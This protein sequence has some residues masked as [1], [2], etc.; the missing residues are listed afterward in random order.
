MSSPCVLTNHGQ[1]GRIGVFV[2]RLL[3][4]ADIH[5]G[6]GSGVGVG[7]SLDVGFLLCLFTVGR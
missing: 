5:T 3:I 4:D 2:R 1:G 6:G 7:K